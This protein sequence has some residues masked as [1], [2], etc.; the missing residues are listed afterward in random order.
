[1]SDLNNE[2]TILNIANKTSEI[3]TKL[4]N[5]FIP[6]ETIFHIET[7][8]SG[9]FDTLEEALSFL[10]G[11]YSNGRVT[12]EF[13]EGTFNVSYGI[14]VDGRNF[15]I[16]EL[17]IQGQGRDKT[18][19][20]CNEEN[21]SHD[22][23]FRFI[24]TTLYIQDLSYVK[25]N[26]N[27]DWHGGFTISFGS[28]AV[29]QN[30]SISGC[31]D[32]IAAELTGT[33][34]IRQTIDINRGGNCILAKGARVDIAMN[35]VLNFNNVPGSCCFFVISGGIIGMNRTD[36]ITINFNNSSNKSNVTPNT[37]TAN[38]IIFGTL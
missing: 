38:G 10:I 32:T 9:D 35:S 26:P 17:V 6:K 1:M 5:N 29:F 28:S 8:G 20:Y 34:S 37:M 36:G 3:S 2:V 22:V 30:V 16:S 15:N 21:P 24:N 18:T 7:D 11:K 14:L 12:I 23:A 33:V 19:L 13:G 25:E 31:W 4:D 27:N